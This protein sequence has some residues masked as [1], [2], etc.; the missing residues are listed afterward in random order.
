M[1]LDFLS[2]EFFFVYLLTVT[3]IQT[4]IEDH[5]LHPEYIDTDTSTN[6]LGHN[7]KE[8]ITMGRKYFCQEFEYVK[9]A[10]GYYT[11]DWMVLKLEDCTGILKSLHPGI[12]IMFLF[13][14][15]CGHDREI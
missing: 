9:I 15:I 8:P 1:I 10:N 12:D 2:Q 3:D 4:I 6:V 5:T 7:H 14:H 13:D 11:Y